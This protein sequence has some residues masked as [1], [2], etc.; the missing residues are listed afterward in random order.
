[1]VQLARA[2]AVG[3]ASALSMALASF[4]QR[5]IDEAE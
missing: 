4:A 5:L 3:A 1:L 2:S